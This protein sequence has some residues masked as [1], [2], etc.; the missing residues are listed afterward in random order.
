MARWLSNLDENDYT[1]KH[2]PGLIIQ[3]EF[4]SRVYGSETLNVNSINS[5]QNNHKS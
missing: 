3:A 1:I 4:L 2:I 5:F